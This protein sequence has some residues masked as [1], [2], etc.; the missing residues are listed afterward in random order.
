VVDSSWLKCVDEFLAPDA[1]RVT[2][3]L[4]DNVGII[5]GQELAED[6][7]QDRT[8][9]LLSAFDHFPVLD[10]LDFL[11]ADDRLG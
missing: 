9:E 10:T 1:P 4:V 5:P 2:M 3:D 6:P 8:V 11:Q 7:A